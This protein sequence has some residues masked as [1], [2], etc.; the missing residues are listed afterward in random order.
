MIMN[1]IKEFR[2]SKGISQA[3]LAKSIGVAQN[4]VSQ[5][6]CGAREPD[7][8]MLIALASYFDVTVD[9]ILGVRPSLDKHIIPVVGTVPAGIPIEAIE[10]V[11]DYEEITPEMA[12][13]GDLFGLR[14][15]GNSMEP[16]IKEG[17]VLIIRKQNTADTGDIVIA[18]V[19]GD[20]EATVK[21][22]AKHENGI[23]L[24]PNNHAYEPMFFTFEEVENLPVRIVGK[25]VE[26]RG[27]F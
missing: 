4:T 1:Y 15:K 26:L 2:K 12:R 19:N 8:D 9:Q 11:L 18:F 6:E 23:S 17:D 27:K 3:S 20:N 10:D 5:W 25:V 7:N 13:M 16:R 24:I 14:V 22:F 21:K